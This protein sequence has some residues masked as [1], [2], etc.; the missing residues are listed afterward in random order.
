MAD[1]LGEAE[2]RSEGVAEIAHQLEGRAASLGDVDRRMIKDICES[3]L[4]YYGFL[5]RSGLVTADE[6]QKFQTLVRSRKQGLIEKMERYNEIRHDGDVDE[7]EKEAIREELFEG[8]HA[9][10][11]L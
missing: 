5:A 4:E 1:Q 10:P 3:L 8:D 11:H 2:S 7:E 6:F 9:W